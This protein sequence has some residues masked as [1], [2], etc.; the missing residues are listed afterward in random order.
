M[1]SGSPGISLPFDSQPASTAKYLTSTLQT[2]VHSQ[3]D[4]NLVH[5]GENYERNLSK[6]VEFVSILSE[7]LRKSE[8]SFF[9]LDIDVMSQNSNEDSYA[10]KG[11]Y[12]RISKE[13]NKTKS[14]KA[15]LNYSSLENIKQ[16]Q[17]PSL[18][19]KDRKKVMCTSKNRVDHNVCIPK[20]KPHKIAKVFK[21]KLATGKASDKSAKL[22]KLSGKHQKKH[23]AAVEHK[24]R[25]VI[26]KLFYF[27]NN[28]YICGQFR[29]R[30]DLTCTL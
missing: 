20:M 14:E 5:V 10:K 7:N 2:D 18:G 25:E 22:A 6:N 26:Y 11:K 3:T 16:K 28:S 29:S 1:E 24:S 13:F 15:N 4:T 17:L 19:E 9:G 23:Q 30:W 21:S 12:R 27:N 8:T